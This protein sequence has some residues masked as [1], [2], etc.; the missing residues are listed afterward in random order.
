MPNALPSAQSSKTGV[1]TTES[2][3]GLQIFEGGRLASQP[4]V[5]LAS[6]SWYSKGDVPT[7][8][9]ALLTLCLKERL[10]FDC[11]SEV[12]SYEWAVDSENVE[13]AYSLAWNDTL[14]GFDVWSELVDCILKVDA[15]KVVV[16]RWKISLIV[17]SRRGSL[18]CVLSVACG[19]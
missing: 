11:L 4:A 7:S 17:A 18:I 2:E 5:R 12:L 19:A 10:G 14:V 8:L 3:E 6:S 16:M 13:E 1:F 9:R 15:S